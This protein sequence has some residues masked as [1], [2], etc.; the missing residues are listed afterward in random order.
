M[1]NKVRHN[2]EFVSFRLGPSSPNVSFH[3]L[4]PKSFR[5][6]VDFATLVVHSHSPAF[7]N[8]YAYRLFLK[9]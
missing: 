8:M 1:R 2:I 7:E 3:Y 6:G 9:V 5:L 4:I